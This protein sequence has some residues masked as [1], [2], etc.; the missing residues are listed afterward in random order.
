MPTTLELADHATRDDLRTYLERLARVGR[1]EA[2]LVARGAVLGVFGCTQAPEGLMDPVPVVLVL[3]SF[4][5]AAASVDDVAE[6]RDDAAPVDVVVP[7]RALLDR[8]ARMG[9]L[10][11]SLDVPDAEVTA[12]WAGVLPPVGGW[13]P[14]GALDADSLA[15]VAA[16]GMARIAEALPDSP[17]DAVV[18]RVRQSVWGAE[19]A[20]G[21]PA[22]AAF[23]A[24]AMGFLGAG[25]GTAPRERGDELA[26]AGEDPGSRPPVRMSATL[27]WRRLA[28]EH[29][30]VLVRMV[31]G[32]PGAVGVG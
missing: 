6:A 26:A 29:G 4:A 21:L 7:V 28:T 20:P 14:V 10:G 5:L 18:R 24:E 3:R 8:I 22:A 13:R 32:E 15:A 27:T 30:D 19:I 31:L 16:E 2:R 11:R 1:P 9:V 25:R 12:A 23:A 17:G